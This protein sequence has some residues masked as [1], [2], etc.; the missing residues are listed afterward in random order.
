MGSD[1]SLAAGPAARPLRWSPTPLVTGLSGR[2]PV[3]TFDRLPVG[4]IAK[5]LP[6]DQHL[7]AAIRRMDHLG[8]LRGS[9]AGA[10]QRTARAWQ[11]RLGRS[12]RGRVVR[13]GEKRGDKVGNTKC[14]KGTKVVDV[15]DSHGT[16]LA[17]HF[18]SA[19]RNDVRLIEPTLDNLPFEEVVPEHLVYDKA[20]DSDALRERLQDERGIELVC[21]HRLNRTR[22]KT[23]DGRALRRYTRR[24]KV[25]RTHSWFQNFRRTL[26]RYETSLTH[27]TTWIYLARVILTLRRS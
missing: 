5:V 2:N 4:K 12:R 17:V 9:L 18:D 26:V 24:Y 22:P 25:E 21:P 16:P 10:A 8:C 3:C 19:S 7:L 15:V 6:F 23:Q 27:Y 11:D 20:A 14:G 13:P 1:Q